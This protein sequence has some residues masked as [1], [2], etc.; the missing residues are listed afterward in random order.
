MNAVS[1]VE[2]DVGLNQFRHIDAVERIGHAALAAWRLMRTPPITT[3]R[4][5]A[6]LE[7]DGG[8]EGFRFPAGRADPS[9]AHKVT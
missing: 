6:Q 4:R 2:F 9:A 1:D 3:I 7:H 5:L 8:R